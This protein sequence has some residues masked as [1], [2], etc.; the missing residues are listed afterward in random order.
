M[1]NLFFLLLTLLSLLGCNKR[2]YPE[3]YTPNRV[4]IDSLIKPNQAINDLIAPYKDSLDQQMNRKI[5]VFAHDM[6]KKKPESE[7]GNFMCD[8]TQEYFNGLSG[9]INAVDLTVMN[10]GGIRVQHISKGEIM[11]E[12]MFELMPFENTVVELS[13]PGNVLH[14]MFEKIAKAG[15]WPVS[16]NVYLEIENQKVK[17]LL[18]N[19]ELIANDKTYQLLTTDYVANGGNGMTMLSGITQKRGKTKLRDI[20]IS[21]CEWKTDMGEEIEAK[22]TGRVKTNN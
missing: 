20:L 18:I 19:G 17:Q 4:D 14:Q 12:T 13:V 3:N 15:G 2:H 10:Y 6:T 22:I 5:G 1:K 11:V 21:Y 8:A 16:N 7:L 9:G